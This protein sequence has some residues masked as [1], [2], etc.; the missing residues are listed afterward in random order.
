[1]RRSVRWLQQRQNC[2]HYNQLAPQPPA[3]AALLPAWPKS[4][5]C[6]RRTN[7]CNCRV[8]TQHITHTPRGPLDAQRR[9]VCV[10]EREGDNVYLF[11]LLLIV[12]VA[13]VVVVVVFA[14]PNANYN[15]DNYVFPADGQVHCKCARSP[16]PSLARSLSLCEL[17]SF[18]FWKMGKQLWPKVDAAAAAA[19]I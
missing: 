10:W 16:S 1:M 19:A 3:R 15:N 5:G 11:L 2:R 4:Q 13:V 8:T 14:E 17:L 9:R 7:T 18:S 12:A 6:W